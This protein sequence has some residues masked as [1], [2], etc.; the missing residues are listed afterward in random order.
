MDELLAKYVKIAEVDSGHILKVDETMENMRFVTNM[1][2][3]YTNKSDNKEDGQDDVEDIHPGDKL[4]NYF[5][6]GINNNDDDD[7]DDDEEDDDDNDR[8]LGNDDNAH[9]NANKGGRQIV[10][11]LLYGRD[12]CK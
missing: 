4:V 6:N 11:S 10:A 2:D 9:G 12:Y 8:D 7:D 3:Q 5:N 1:D